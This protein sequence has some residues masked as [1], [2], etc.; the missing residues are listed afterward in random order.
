M[1]T[2]TPDESH[3]ADDAGTAGTAP[4]R[5]RRRA[6]WIALAANAVFMVAEVAGGLAFDSLA[7]LADAAHMLSDVAALGVA[8]VA[9]QLATR[10]ASV[11]HSFGLRRAEV[12]GAQLNAVLLLVAAGW[13]LIEAAD[14]VG[15]PRSVEGT[16]ML[17][18]ATL[19]LAVNL[20]SAWVIHQSA[21]R[22]L[23]MRGAFL[24]MVV[25]A[26]G[27]VGAV[28][29]GVAVVGWGA[30]VIDPIV[31]IAIAALVVWA[32]LHLL[33]EAAHVVLEGTPRHLDPEAIERAIADSPGVEAVHHLHVW[34]IASD[35]PALSAHMVMEDDMTLH[36]AQ[37]RAVAVK[38]DLAKRFGIAHATLE[39]ECH[40]CP[41][42]DTGHDLPSAS[43][44]E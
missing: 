3:T 31:S 39:V 35:F 24:H 25:D 41:T 44:R 18:V 36:E 28:A 27:S 21:G 30:D 8:L 7:L 32:A 11:R 43:A 37:E 42:P 23:N 40:E 33:L 10:P 5:R 20:G 34:N 38:A 1:R 29:A 12:L 22:D 4:H 6:L 9:Q 16:G 13:I 2:V 17:V 19:G 14:R 15:S 26:A